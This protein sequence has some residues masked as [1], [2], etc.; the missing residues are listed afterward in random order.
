MSQGFKGRNVLITRRRA[1]L[2]AAVVAFSI[3]AAYILSPARNP[4]ERLAR[5]CV[6][7]YWEEHGSG[8]KCEDI[9]V[10]VRKDAQDGFYTEGRLRKGEPLSGFY[11]TIDLRD[12]ATDGSRCVCTASRP[13]ITNENTFQP[14]PAQITVSL[15]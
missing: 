8:W 13:E 10:L 15:K 5:E 6:R 2:L 3:G 4:K 12:V 9:D 11:L 1:R 7:L 14:K